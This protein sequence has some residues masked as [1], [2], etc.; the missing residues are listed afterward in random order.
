MIEFI[1]CYQILGLNNNAP[2]EQIKHSFRELSLK[3]HPDHNN[4]SLEST[5]RFRMILNAYG[6][7]SDSEKRAEYDQYLEMSHFVGK[8]NT[9]SS[10]IPLPSAPRNMV[11]TADT[12][13]SDVNF[14]L[15]EVEDLL[16]DRKLDLD[17]RPGNRSI[18][19]YIL[20]IITF[21]DKWV[22]GPAGSGDYF[23]EARGLEEIDPRSYIDLL[24]SGNYPS[25]HTPYTS[26]SGYFYDVRKRTGKL[27]FNDRTLHAPIPGYKISLMECILE[28]KDLSVHYLS[29]L[30]RVQKGEEVHIKDFSFTSSIF[31]L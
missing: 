22:L 1:S 30:L 11:Q 16:A 28:A 31:D 27:S 29:S 23:M 17:I 5:N 15:W 19:E 2:L 3:Y 18:R 25:A 13:L 12:L 6:I 9:P 26:I 8:K 24:G 21:L 4:N 10:A 20:I 7:L 14:I